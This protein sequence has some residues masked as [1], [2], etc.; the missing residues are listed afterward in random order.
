[1]NIIKNAITEETAELATK[2]AIELLGQDVWR[3]NRDTWDKDLLCGTSG[4]VLIAQLD[5]D[6]RKL[7]LD[8]VSEQLPHHN[9]NDLSI[10]FHVGLA[11]SGIAMHDDSGHKFGAT[12]Y[13]NKVWHPDFGGLFLWMEDENNPARLKA[14][15]PE[16]RSMVLND[17]YQNHMVTRVAPK[18]S[19]IRLT[20]QIFGN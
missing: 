10:T 1:M 16:Y 5:S 13:L 11:E 4:K 9:D 17:E 12:I 14:Y 20:I 7:V 2:R 19:E 18:L 6:I 15:V 8:D 3:S